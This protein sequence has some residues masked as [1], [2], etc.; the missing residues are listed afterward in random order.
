MLLFTG[1]YFQSDIA[2]RYR[3]IHRRHAAIF[4]ARLLFAHRRISFIIFVAIISA[5]DEPP[6][7][8]RKKRAD[9]HHDEAM[10]L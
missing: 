10:P 7:R 8:R 6:T 4:P 1:H 2:R 3:N 9:A 5:N